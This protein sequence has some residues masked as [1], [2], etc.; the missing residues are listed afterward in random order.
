MIIAGIGYAFVKSDPDAFKKDNKGFKR[1][2]ALDRYL[3]NLLNIK[4][5]RIII[6]TVALG[7]GIGLLLYGMRSH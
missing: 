4:E 2:S 7:I 1:L 3:Y 6:V 5:V